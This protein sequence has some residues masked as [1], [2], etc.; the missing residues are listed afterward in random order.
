MWGLPTFGSLEVPK[1]F[2]P[3]ENGRD[4]RKRTW[5][6]GLDGLPQWS[7]RPLWGGKGSAEG[8][9]PFSRLARYESRKL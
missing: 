4:F 9:E 6:R 1:I 3:E 8:I 2:V 7:G 5:F